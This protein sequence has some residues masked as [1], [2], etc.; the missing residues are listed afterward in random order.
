MFADR[1]RNLDPLLE[2]LEH[3]SHLRPITP[4]LILLVGTQQ[5]LVYL[6]IERLV[7]AEVN[8][9]LPYRSFNLDGKLADIQ[10]RATVDN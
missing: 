2:L 7:V 6:P 9:E 3:D 4:C 10:L 5:E 8:G 1:S